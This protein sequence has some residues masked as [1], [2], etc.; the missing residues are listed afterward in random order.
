MKQSVSQRKYIL[1]ACFAF[2]KWWV[3]KTP[4]GLVTKDSDNKTSAN[5]RRKDKD[6]SQV[7]QWWVKAQLG[8]TRL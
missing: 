7:T 4:F 8:R 3:G 5:E 6:K 2:T 1:V